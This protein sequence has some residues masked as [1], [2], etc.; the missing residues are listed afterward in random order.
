MVGKGLCRPYIK[1]TIYLQQKLPD[2]EPTGQEE[3]AQKHLCT[4]GNGRMDREERIRKPLKMSCSN[5]FES[6]V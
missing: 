1:E 5:S 3:G 6:K 2:R 4:H